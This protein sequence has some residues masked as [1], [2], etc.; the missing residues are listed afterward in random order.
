MFVP[1]SHSPGHAQCDFG[2]AWVII[3]GVE[4]KALVNRSRPCPAFFFTPRASCKRPFA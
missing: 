3:G 1:L 2:E 4:R